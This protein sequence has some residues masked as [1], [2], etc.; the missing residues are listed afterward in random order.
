MPEAIADGFPK[1]QALVQVMEVGRQSR[2]VN[3]GFAPEEAS[4][5]SAFHTR[6]FM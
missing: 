6:N 2:L 1:M 3:L 4:A 5:L